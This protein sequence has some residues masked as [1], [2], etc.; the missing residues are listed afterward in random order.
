MVRIFTA[1]VLYSRLNYDLAIIRSFGFF[2]PNGYH[3]I[4]G[5]AAA[6]D[7]CRIL[8]LNGSF[9]VWES[10][11]AYRVTGNILY[12]LSFLFPFRIFGSKKKSR[13]VVLHPIAQ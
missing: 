9:G 7:G 1:E 3:V 2:I 6:Y 13:G 5:E 10:H 12:P 8:P 11:S 4:I